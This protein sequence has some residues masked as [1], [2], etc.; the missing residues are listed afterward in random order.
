LPTIISGWNRIGLTNLKNRIYSQIQNYDSD[1]KIIGGYYREQAGNNLSYKTI[2][3]ILMSSNGL[4]WGV[5][6]NNAQFSGRF[7]HMTCVFNN[8]IYLFG[9]YEY[10]PNYRIY[11]KDL[12]KNVDT[13]ASS[14]IKI[15]NNTVYPERAFGSMFVF[16]N[17]MWIMGGVNK[18]Q[19]LS[20]IWN[21]SDGINWNQVL[22]NAPWGDRYNFATIIYNNKIWIIGGKYYY[23]QYYKDVWN[24][25]D[26]ITWN[27]VGDNIDIL[28]KS[29]FD[30]VTFNNRMYI[31]GGKGYGNI[32]YE[33]K[34]VLESVDGVHWYNVGNLNIKNIPHISNVYDDKIFIVTFSEGYSSPVY[35]N[36]QP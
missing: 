25:V 9:G 11:K 29:Y 32:S 2:S 14:W 21:S 6:T 28:D 7:G 22:N 23:E 33:D 3:D 4:N 26:G 34:K 12:W 5:V 18:T 1:M 24:S 31:I 13:V 8:K 16:N 10:G 17:K 36:V 19:G 20:D 30:G 35:I 27:K 15:N